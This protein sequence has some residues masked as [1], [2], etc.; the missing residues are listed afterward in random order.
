LAKNNFVAV[1]GSET[2]AGR[3]IRDLAGGLPLEVR[4]IAADEEG[5]GL[6]T[7]HGGEAAVVSGLDQVALSGARIVFL[8]GS[9]ESSQKALELPTEGTFID[10]TYAAEDR[11]NARLRAPMVEPECFGAPGDAVQVIANPAAIAIALVVTRLHEVHPV[12]RTVVH[13]FEP[14]SERGVRGVEEL[15]QQT[16]N[17]LSFKSLPKKIFDEQLGFNM[18]ARYGEEAPFALEDAEARLE[19]HLATLL[20]LADTAVPMPSLRLI[21]VPVFHGHGFSLWIEFDENPGAAEVEAVLAAQNID[22]RDASVE[23]PTVVGMAGQSGVAIGAVAVDRNDPEA[24]WV[25]MAA[26]NLRLQGENAIA[27]ARQFL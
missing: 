9:P 23:P 22:V 25:W 6:L 3:E 27:V 26:D 19:R 11:P 15:Q 21:Q 4:L 8:A 24:C 14:A 18:L 7:E 12:R 17:L 13:V 20:A 5:A 2:L 1:V 16:V 10:L